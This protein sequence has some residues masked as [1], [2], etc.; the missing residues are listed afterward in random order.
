[1]TNLIVVFTSKHRRFNS[2]TKRW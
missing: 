1:L 2:P